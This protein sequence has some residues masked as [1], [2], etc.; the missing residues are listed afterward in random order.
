[1]HETPEDIHA[2]QALLDASHA[3][4][5]P[6]LRAIWNEERRIPAAELPEILTGV[7]TITLA[8]VT[9]AGEPRIVPVDGLFFAGRF[10]AG[11][12]RDSVR[13]RHL[14]ARPQVSVALVRGEELAV[15]VHGHAALVDTDAP[16][17]AAF[18]EYCLEVYGAPWHS[19][20]AGEPYARIEPAK[21]FTFRNPP[22]GRSAE[23]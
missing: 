8:T 23:A 12:T 4:A 13:L 14:R 10:Y 22:R 1:V 2:L 5:G 17:H 19:F 16:E 3:A 9:A 6:H 20:G 21:M 15:V 11:A 7:Q 18:R